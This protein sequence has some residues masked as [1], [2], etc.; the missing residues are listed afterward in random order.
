M[1]TMLVEKNPEFKELLE[2]YRSV[3]IVIKVY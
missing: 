2:A 1:V 3:Q